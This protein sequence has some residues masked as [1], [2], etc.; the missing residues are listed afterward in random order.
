MGEVVDDTINERRVG[1][2]GIGLL[3]SALSS[4]PS[5]GKHGDNMG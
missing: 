2:D 1:W 3:K 4:S 5:M